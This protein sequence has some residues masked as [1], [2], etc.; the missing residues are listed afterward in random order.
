MANIAD[1]TELRA[2]LFDLT[3][4]NTSGSEIQDI[5]QT[6]PKAVA[7][8]LF[9]GGG[10]GDGKFHGQAKDHLIYDLELEPES[11][12]S[13]VAEG[14]IEPEHYRLNI[15]ASEGFLR[16]LSEKFGKEVKNG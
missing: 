12:G 2:I 6:Y 8:W 10:S 13:G 1:G 11:K 4:E 3:G 9:E 15:K 16:V 7:E 5:L 14:T